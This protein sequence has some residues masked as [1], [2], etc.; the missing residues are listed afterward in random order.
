[1]IFSAVRPDK[2]GGGSAEKAP[3]DGIVRKA[4]FHNLLISRFS[5][6][7]DCIIMGMDREM[8]YNERL[9]SGGSMM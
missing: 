4:Y 2:R 5:S 9:L 6:R 7:P 8:F 3:I 1:M